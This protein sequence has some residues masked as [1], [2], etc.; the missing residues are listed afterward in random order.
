[1][2]LKSRHGSKVILAHLEGYGISYDN[3]KIRKHLKLNETYTIDDLEVDDWHSR[4]SLKEIPNEWFNTIFFEN[5]GYNEPTSEDITEDFPTVISPKF[6][7]ILQNYHLSEAF[8]SLGITK[9]SSNE[10]I[11]KAFKTL[12]EGEF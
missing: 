8:K 9:D 7:K 10:E 11:V 2:N 6:R 3:E 4:V 12:F 5:E 1:M